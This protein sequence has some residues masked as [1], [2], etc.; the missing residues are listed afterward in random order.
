VTCLT[1][2]STSLIPV[3]PLYSRESV[4]MLVPVKHGQLKRWETRNPGI[5]SEPKL[6]TGPRTMP[7][8]LYRASDIVALRSAL[9][10]SRP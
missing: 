5:L 1:C 10:R 4:M 2:G 6:Y 7:R 8:R 9:V 3:E